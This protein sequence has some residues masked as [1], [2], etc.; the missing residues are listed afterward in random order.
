MKKDYKLEGKII[1]YLHWLHPTT[2]IKNIISLED[3]DNYYSVKCDVVEQVY[4]TL[5]DLVLT[6]RVSK[7]ALECHWRIEEGN[8]IKVKV[9]GEYYRLVDEERNILRV[10]SNYSQ[11]MFWDALVYA[12][13]FKDTVTIE[14][15]TQWETDEEEEL[16]FRF[17]GYETEVDGYKGQTVTGEY[18]V[19]IP[20]S[21]A[22]ELSR[23]SPV[24]GW[25][26][27]EEIEI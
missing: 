6:F 23:Y 8:K 24:N 4:E 10:Y 13:W 22:D 1:G 9:I 5:N 19:S 2:R 7:K 21:F 27:P 11:D 25:V 15:V 26:I 3:Y 18:K 20:T 17:F 14:R 16:R 12:G